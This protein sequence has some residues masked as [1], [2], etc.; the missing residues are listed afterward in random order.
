MLGKEH[1]EKEEPASQENGLASAV[2]TARS[3][4]WGHIT[5]GGCWAPPGTHED[6]V[7]F[8]TCYTC[9]FPTAASPRAWAPSHS[10]V[11]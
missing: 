9:P 11:C 1:R 10:P 5:P 2:V 6:A 3:E 8:G 4:Y 7:G